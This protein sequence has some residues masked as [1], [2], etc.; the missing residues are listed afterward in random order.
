MK[1]SDSEYYANQ[2]NP[3][4]FVSKLALHVRVKMFATLMEITQADKNTQVLDVGVTNDRRTE[5]NFLEKLYPYP[6]NITAVGLEEA[7]FIETEFPGVKYIK[8]DGKAL[9]FADDSFD[10]V[11]SFAVIEHVGSR[12]HQNNFINELCRVGKSC[13]ITTPNRWYPVEVHTMT[14]FLHWLP[15]RQFRTILRLMGKHFYADE[16]NLNLLD[17][18]TLQRMFPGQMQVEAHHYRLIGMVSN[19]FYYA[20]W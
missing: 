10:L 4:N 18:K 13:L 7:S 1:T 9:P 15:A 16:A 3:G 12:N 2:P 14:P 11:T 17:A 8:A 6:E 19:L 20:K 5:S